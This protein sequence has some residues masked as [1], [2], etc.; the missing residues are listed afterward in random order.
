MKS[1]MQYI[2]EACEDGTC[3]S[4]KINLDGLDTCNDILKDLKNIEIASI[5]DKEVEI[6]QSAD[7]NDLKKV[8]DILK[9][10]SDKERSSQHRSSDESYAQKTKKLEDK[11]NAL[12]EMIE[13]INN[14]TPAEQNAEKEEKKEKEE[15]KDDKKE[16]E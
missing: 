8:Y 5:N 10:Y 12:S 6:V 2:K 1:L 14:P 4:V 13:Q 7:V 11:V 9:K 15:N 16:D 3:S